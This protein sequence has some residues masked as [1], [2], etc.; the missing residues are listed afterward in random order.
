MSWHEPYIALGVAALWGGYGA[1]YF[2]ASSKKKGKEILL[3]GKPSV[4]V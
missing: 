1:F 3:T 4:A 2:L